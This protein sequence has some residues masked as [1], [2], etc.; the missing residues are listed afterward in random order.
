MKKVVM[1]V[2]L[3]LIIIA[4]VVFVVK[5][6]GGTAPSI[7]KVLATRPPY[8]MMDVTDPAHPVIAEVPALAKELEYQQQQNTGYLKDPKTGKIYAGIMTC[9]SCGK[10][11]PNPPMPMEVGFIQKGTI[12]SQYKCPLC[13]NAATNVSP[14]Q[15]P[16]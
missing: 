6:M 14:P 7:A 12:L 10:E 4:A 16:D 13:G 8:K 1:G 2:V 11:I 15:L 5:R 3:V 9:L